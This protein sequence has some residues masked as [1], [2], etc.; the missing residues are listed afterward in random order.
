MRIRIYKTWA[1]GVREG[2]DTQCWCC[3]RWRLERTQAPEILC[4]HCL[5][6]LADIAKEEEVANKPKR[7][8]KWS[9]RSFEKEG[10]RVP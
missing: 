7:K 1:E 6:G 9:M 2:N 10:G 3:K 4:V 8:R 5:N